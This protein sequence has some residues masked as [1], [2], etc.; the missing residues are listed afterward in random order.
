M[1]LTDVLKGLFGNDVSITGRT[2]VG[3][4]D[5]NEAFILSLSNGERL[6]LKRN[7][8]MPVSF[9]E[10]EAAG[11]KALSS[12]GTIPVVSAIGSGSDEEGSFLLL[13]FVQSGRRK[14]DFW[15]DFG[16]NLAALHN[17]DASSFTPGGR[18]GFSGDNFIGSTRQINSVRDSFIDFFRECRLELQFKMAWDYFDQGQGRVILRLL[19]RLGDLLLE[20][21]HPSLLHGDLWGGNFMTD[22][23]GSAMFIDPAVYVGHPEA[24]IAMTELFGGF[25]TEF[26]RSYREFYD[27]QPGY[28]DRRDLYNL[29]QL[30]NHL[31]LFGCGYLGSV[32]RIVERF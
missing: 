25:D 31:N 1:T 30:L 27:M 24:D 23:T 14:K 28:A 10:A 8:R 11:L 26:Y 6:F 17:A 12:T 20:P 13:G 3:G 15:R 22:E 18:F 9:F 5:I 16:R 29:Y 32:L 7:R 4:G 19:D 21:A 2:G